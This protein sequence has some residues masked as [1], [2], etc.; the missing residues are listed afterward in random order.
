[1]TEYSPP[2]IIGQR[3]LAGSLSENNSPFGASDAEIK[4]GVQPVRR[5]DYEAPE[6]TSER[7]LEGRLGIGSDPT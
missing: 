2:E 6:I 7:R 4:H 1:M 3:A 5:A